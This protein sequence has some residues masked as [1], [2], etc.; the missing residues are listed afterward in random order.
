VGEL[1]HLMAV[2]LRVAMQAGGL[3]GTDNTVRYAVAIEPLLHQLIDDGVRAGWLPP[4]AVASAHREIAG[5]LAEQRGMQALHARLR[6]IDRLVERGAMAEATAA[7]LELL[8]DMPWCD[9]RAEEDVVLTLDRRGLE[10][11][12]VAGYDIV[13]GRRNEDGGP[14]YHHGLVTWRR[15]LS[16]VADEGGRWANEARQRLDR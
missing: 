14:L 9:D 6:K 7:S 16:R 15:K 5:E 8:A 11:A 4:H 3:R 10:E 1:E 13:Q 2:D 12:M